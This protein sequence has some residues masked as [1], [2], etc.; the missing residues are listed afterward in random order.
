MSC[1]PC[2]KDVCQECY[3]SGK[4][5]KFKD[6]NTKEFKGLFNGTHPEIDGGPDVKFKIMVTNQ[7]IRGVADKREFTLFG[8]VYSGVVAFD[9][10]D[11]VG[12]KSVKFLGSVNPE[13]TAI[14]GDYLTD[15]GPKGSAIDGI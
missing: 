15:S 6:T 9:V 2:N 13:G 10:F 5:E 14:L 8:K 1:E 7:E 12:V 3:E 11:N 4:W